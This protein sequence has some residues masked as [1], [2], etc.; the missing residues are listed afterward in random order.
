MRETVGLGF[1]TEEAVDAV[2]FSLHELGVQYDVRWRHSRRRQIGTHGLVGV[3]ALPPD[4]LVQLAESAVDRDSR[5][6]SAIRTSPGRAR[7][8]S[9]FR[10]TCRYA[11][12]RCVW[13]QD[14]GPRRC[15]APPSHG[16]ASTVRGDAV[17]PGNSTPS[18]SAPGS[19]STWPRERE[20]E[21][22]NTATGIR[23][24][25]HL[26]AFQSGIPR[27]PQH[28]ALD[29]GQFVDTETLSEPTSAST[30]SASEP[31]AVEERQHQRTERR[32]KTERLSAIPLA[33]DL[34]GLVFYPKAEFESRGVRSSG[35]VG[36][37]RSPSLVRSWPTV[38]RRGVSASPSGFDSVDG[39]GLT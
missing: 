27:G 19:R 34:K 38:A 31:L 18:P 1:A 23:A 9:T 29:I 17:S 13:H 11:V 36:R 26:V 20:P 10:R 24:P 28:R 6:R 12:G 25:R 39:R 4:E 3:H 22:S 32:Q 14:P 7:R 5:K 15:R 16:A 37:V 35:H 2:H 30:C 8:P 21:T 33:I